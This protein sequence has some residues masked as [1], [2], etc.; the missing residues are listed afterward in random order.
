M[1]AVYLVIGSNV[2][3]DCEIGTP[4]VEYGGLVMPFLKN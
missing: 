1:P 4:H 2:S 3:D